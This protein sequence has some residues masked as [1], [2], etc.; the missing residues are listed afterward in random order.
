MKTIDNAFV[1]LSDYTMQN[2]DEQKNALTMAYGIF[3]SP[4]EY[5]KWDNFTFP[6]IR[7][8]IAEITN[9]FQKGNLCVA[10]EQ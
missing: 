9:T 1:Q 10:R 2:R 4:N 7:F 8:E 6:E 5:P 3:V